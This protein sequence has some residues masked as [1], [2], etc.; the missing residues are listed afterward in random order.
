MTGLVLRRVGHGLLVVWAAYTLTFLLLYV[1]PGDPVTTM[2]SGTGQVEATPEQVARLRAH[3]GLDS[4]LPVQY[5]HALAG[6]VTGDLGTS[7]LTGGSVSSALAETV[8][9]T[10]RLAVAALVLGTTAGGAVAVAAVYTRHRRLARVLAALPV[11][12]VSV[13]TF[14]VGLLLLQIFSFQLGWVPALGGGGLAGVVLPALTLA[15]PVAATVGQVLLR[16]LSDTWTR[17]FVTTFHA[18]GVPRHRLLVSHALR[19][20]LG[21]VLSVAGVLAGE[22]LGGAVVVETVFT[23]NGVG[24]LLTTSVTAQD[25]PVVLG[26]VLF[27]AVVFVTVNIAAD[28]LRPVVDARTAP[29][30]GPARRRRATARP[31]PGRIPA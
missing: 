15:V 11:L 12:G 31:E 7:Y 8:P 3:Y 30:N 22:L 13:P 14:W 21:P 25:V 23:R 27:S 29:T 26:V 1:L 28:L 4:S 16:T 10:V 6:L 9:G 18:A 5:L 2:L 24:R 19:A 17:Q 20:S